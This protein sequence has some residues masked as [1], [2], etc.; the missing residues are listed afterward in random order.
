MSS[1]SPFQK[2]P[3]AAG[4]VG[5]PVLSVD[6]SF[7][8]F[9]RERGQK[10]TVSKRNDVKA[11]KISVDS[12]HPEQ[13]SKGPVSPPTTSDRNIHFF[14]LSFKTLSSDQEKGDIDGLV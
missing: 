11:C 9:R 5:I 14:F 8:Q 7:S 6:S 2:C 1:T 3:L 4:G 12:R 10:I 13:I